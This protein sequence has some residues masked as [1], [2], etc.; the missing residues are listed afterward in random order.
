MKW[1][2]IAAQRCSI[3]RALSVV[4]DTWTMLVVRELFNG[5][6]RF[7]GLLTETGAPPAVLSDRLAGLEDDGVVSKRPYSQR[8]DR[9]EYRLTAKGRDLYPVVVSLMAW[10]DRWMPNGEP[11]PVQLRHR[12]CGHLTTPTLTCSACGGSIDPR[13]M[14]RHTSADAVDATAAER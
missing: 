4:G 9:F 8:A 10:G 6:R 14:D 5:N 3:A 12:T 2:D 1:S 13:E 11:P 7:N